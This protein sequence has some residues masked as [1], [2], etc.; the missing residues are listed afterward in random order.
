[1]TTQVIRSEEFLRTMR[2]AVAFVS[3]VVPSFV[4]H[5]RWVTVEAFLTNLAAHRL[6]AQ[7]HVAMILQR[8]QITTLHLSVQSK[9]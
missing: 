1:M 9:F 3:G 4:H 7:M 5:E 8:K 6:G 2:T